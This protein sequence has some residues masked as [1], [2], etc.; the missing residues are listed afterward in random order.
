MRNR[1]IAVCVVLVGCGSANSRNPS[2]LPS[3]ALAVAAP[4]ATTPDDAGTPAG[5]APVA[6]PSDAGP[7]PLQEVVACV[8][9]ATADGFGVD[10]QVPQALPDGGTDPEQCDIY[11]GHQVSKCIGYNIWSANCHTAAN[12]TTI[13]N[14]GAG[15]TG[16]YAC[17][18]TPETSPGYHTIN[19]Q[20][21]QSPN[22]PDGGTC[23]CMYGWGV[24]CCFPGTGIP[25]TI[26][27]PAAQACA[28]Q[29]CLGQNTPDAGALVLPPGQLVEIPGPAVC[30]QNVS[31]GTNFSA[32]NNAACLS[33]CDDRANAWPG[34]QWGRNYKVEFLSAC[35]SL[36][37][38]FFGNNT[39]PLVD[40][41]TRAGQTC[42]SQ[43][44]S[45][46]LTSYLEQ[47]RS[48]CY[49]SAIAGN[50]PQANAQSCVN[51]C[52]Q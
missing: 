8:I 1:L 7:A 51:L 32:S 13:Q 34:N 4:V 6:G 25:P 15:D 20:V 27:T 44:S 3:S 2:E 26:N 22:C 9:D 46:T 41:T 37:N 33:C 11:L 47:C 39:T 16:I 30:V 52:T 28:D 50:F 24:P 45:W 35:R 31:G 18:G 38:G 36:C 21:R 10:Q 19:W 40:L 48:C 14:A 17:A 42:K 23:T 29:L 49:D 5:S 43:L 12:V